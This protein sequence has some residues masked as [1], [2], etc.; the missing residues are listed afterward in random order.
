MNSEEA[1]FFKVVRHFS[2]K[3][4]ARCLLLQD[5]CGKIP[6]I[7]VRYSRRYFLPYTTLR[8]SPGPLAQ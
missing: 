2:V 6:H 8:S 7:F 4:V 1:S 3:D 5:A